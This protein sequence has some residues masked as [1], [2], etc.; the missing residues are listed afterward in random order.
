MSSS[1]ELGDLAES[2]VPVAQQLIGAVH[3]DGP[4]AVARVFAIVPPAHLQALAIVLA[5][6]CDPTKK[7][8][9]ML[10]WVNW[11]GVTHR[12]PTLFD[13]TLD[14]EDARGWSD[15]E[16]H[17][18]WRQYR[19][20]GLVNGDNRYSDVEKIRLRRGY[21]EWERRRAERRRKGHPHEAR[22]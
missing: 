17:L 2:L 14:P 7:P 5:G 12:D 1:E 10:A 9:D 11:D 18:L 22:L 15:S 16:C 21:L 4:G 13:G 19:S 20:A 8:S 3:D 6:M